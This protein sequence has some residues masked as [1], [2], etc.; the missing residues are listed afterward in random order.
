MTLMPSY[1]RSTA[2]ALR[3]TAD[4]LPPD[5]A[6]LADAITFAGLLGCWVAGLLGCWVAGLLGVIYDSQDTGQAPEAVSP[7][8][9]AAMQLV[10]EVA[11]PLRK[12]KGTG[13]GFGLT[14]GERRAVEICA[15]THAV[16]YLKERGYITKDVS[17]AESYDLLATDAV[18]Q[19]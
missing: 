2:L 13:Q 10:D 5:E 15:M 19:E 1:E 16:T 3:Y 7:E 14:A 9:A 18:G 8:V 17:A 6:L 11:K 12:R 4:A